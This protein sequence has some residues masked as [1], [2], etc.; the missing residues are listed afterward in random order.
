MT[1]CAAK[2]A[3]KFKRKRE[4]AIVTA[5]GPL[6]RRGWEDEES[7]GTSNGS[8]ESEPRV[9]GSVQRREAS[10]Q[11]RS[12]IRL[13]RLLESAED[14]RSG[15]QMFL[16]SRAVGPLSQKSYKIAVSPDQ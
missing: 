8:L 7:D 4:S 11:K 15:G 6:G 3:N 13:R 5:V 12:K 1:P 16:E 2:P 9:G 14:C 10:I